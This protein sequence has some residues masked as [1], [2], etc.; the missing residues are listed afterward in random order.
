L[1][2]QH[3]TEL[4]IGRLVWN[5]QRYVKDLQ[6]GKRISRLNPTSDWIITEVPALRIVDDH[7]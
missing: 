1:D 5:R 7:L 4:Y 2:R 6:T 3:N